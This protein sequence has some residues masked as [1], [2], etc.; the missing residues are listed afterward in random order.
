MKTP[1][2]VIAAAVVACSWVLTTTTACGAGA[3]APRGALAKAENLGRLFVGGA[4]EQQSREIQPPGGSTLSTLKARGYFCY[5]GVDLSSFWTIMGGAGNVEVKAAQG[6]GYGDAD[7]CWFAGTQIALL[8]HRIA[9]PAYF[10]GTVRIDAR[11]AHWDFSADLR[12]DTVQWTE[13]RAALVCSGEFPVRHAVE[14]PD[15]VPYSSV[16][17]IG[18]VYSIV[19]GD[20]T[21]GK[22]WAG[23]HAG[24]GF[25]EAD[26]FGLLLGI[27]IKFAA[28]WSAGWEGRRYGDEYTHT[29]TAVF[30]F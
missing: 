15:A 5:A 22:P 20:V 10:E 24:A 4:V 23:G 16:L 9:A 26:E 11:Y 17:S 25:E 30:H 3:D 13:D 29:V 28:N 14:D 12:G 7:T 1:V 6:T 21:G 27:D 19:D 18:P 8:E 2:L